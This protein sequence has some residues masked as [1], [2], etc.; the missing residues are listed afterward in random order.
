MTCPIYSS[1]IH[2]IS[3]AFFC[4]NQCFLHI[5][6]DLI[7]TFVASLLADYDGG[8]EDDYEELLLFLL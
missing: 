2:K 8:G 5:Y 7:A 1:R 6:M 4:K 3:L